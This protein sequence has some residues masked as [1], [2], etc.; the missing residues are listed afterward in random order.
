MKIG[1]GQNSW[2]LGVRGVIAI[3]FGLYA[4]LVPGLALATLILAFG[5][6]ILLQGILAIVAA[7]RVHDHDQRSL[8]IALEGIVCV[9]VGLFAL[10]GPNVAAL[11]WLF[12]AS[13]FAVVSGV[14]HMAGA[15]QLRKHF[16]GEWVLILN[17]ALTT[18]FGIL[19]ILMPMAGLLAL[20]W[21]LGAYSVL[22]GVLLLAV[23][24]RLRA[25]WRATQAAAA[26]AA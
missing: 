8:P 21:L 15:I 23:A 14:L 22:F 25:R 5:A 26:R 7:V 6:C 12:L 2:I 19:M 1:M 3:L 11:T 10:V 17:G 24:L 13:G 4:L 9:I 20:V 18:L 16:A